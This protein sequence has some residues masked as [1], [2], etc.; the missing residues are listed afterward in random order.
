MAR[1]RA[2]RR[3][4]AH[5]PSVSMLAAR[6][7]G[8]EVRASAGRFFAR[9]GDYARAGEQGELIQAVDA[10]HPAGLYLKAEGALAT[11]K[12]EE[13]GKL[14]RAAVD[15][16]RDPQ[17]LDGQGRVCIR[18]TATTHVIFDVAGYHSAA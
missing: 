16:D 15:A 2:G 9:H 10:T 7:P 8:V 6:D 11:G 18:A 17:Y 14:F 13:A 3:T 12:V 1:E 4:P 5:P